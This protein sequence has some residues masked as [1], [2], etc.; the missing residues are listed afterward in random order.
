MCVFGW[1]TGHETTKWTMEGERDLKGHEESREGYSGA[2]ATL[3]R[4][5]TSR[6]GRGLREG[7]LGQGSTK[8]RCE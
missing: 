5:R 3:R 2:G 8:T 7:G 1:V 4:K 6:E